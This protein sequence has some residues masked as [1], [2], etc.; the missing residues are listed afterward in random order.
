[1]VGP[2]R[3]YADRVTVP[4]RIALVL[5]VLGLATLGW[6][7][8]RSRRGRVR[9]VTGRAR[10]S[11]LFPGLSPQ[12]PAVVQISSAHCSTCAQSVRAWT[13]ALDADRGE[14]TLRR[15][16]AGEDAAVA[17][18]EIDAE[19]H[20]DAV[21]ALNILTTPTSLLFDATGALVGRVTGAPRG[22]EAAAAVRTIHPSTNGDP[23]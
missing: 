18:R 1:M 21:R 4:A 16:N 2:G 12:G 3:P 13:R 11:G 7:L 8:L 9:E 10:L 15:E 23:S 19:N 17:F 20:L 22:P 14:G 6:L 5:A